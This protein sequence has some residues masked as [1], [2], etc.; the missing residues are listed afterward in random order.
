MD[1]MRRGAL[2]RIGY[3][4]AGGMAGGLAWS[5]A[6]AQSAAGTSWPSRPVRVVYPYPPGGTG[7][8]LV[9]IITERLSKAWGQPVVVENR[10]G[11]GG[12]IGT[13]AVARSAPDGYT[14]LVA[15][16]GLVQMP[17]VTKAPFDPVRDFAP[18]AEIG[19]THWALAVQPDLPVRNVADFV[20]YAKQLGKP[21]PFGTYSPA[22]APHIQ[23]ALLA[24]AQGFEPT[25]VHY[26]G[27]APLLQDLLG[28]QIGCGAL[29]AT[30]VQKQSAKLRALAVNGNARSPL[31]PDV[32]TFAEAGF[33][34]LEQPGFIG[35]LAPA[36]TPAA[37]V[38]RISQDVI[39][40]LADPETK[41]RLDDMGI[42]LRPGTAAQFSQTVRNEFDY[43]TKAVRT[44]GV[45]LE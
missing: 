28:R 16:T 25:F 43:W 23:I 11:A 35:M 9:R 38:E 42:L 27:E 4:V 36:G 41:A 37:L 21:L 32:P 6:A 13:E 7:D 39:Q 31:L 3:G 18:I 1:Q 45:R 24:Q 20:A 17:V 22:T 44:T 30:T 34:G 2:R 26:R 29:A 19:T 15:I 33:T 5:T 40:A 8:V 12:M 10:P 14:L